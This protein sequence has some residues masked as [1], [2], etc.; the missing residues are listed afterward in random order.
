[1]KETP[2]PLSSLSNKIHALCA[3][4][5]HD[6]PTIYG[7]WA[8]R[9][10]EVKKQ[11]GIYGDEEAWKNDVIVRERDK[12]LILSALKTERIIPEDFPADLS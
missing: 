4:T 6:L 8:G 9:D 10:I 7:Y 11:L 2:D 5:T 1:L 12:G 3:I